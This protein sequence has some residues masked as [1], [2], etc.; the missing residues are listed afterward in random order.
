[1]VCIV[2]VGFSLGEEKSR[3]LGWKVSDGGFFWKRG[4]LNDSYR[5]MDKIWGHNFSVKSIPCRK[6]FGDLG[7]LDPWSFHPQH[8]ERGKWLC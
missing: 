6:C 5:E 3:F 1:M 4:G 8:R 7:M 2:S